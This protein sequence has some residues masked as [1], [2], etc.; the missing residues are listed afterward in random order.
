MVGWGDALYD[1][2]QRIR[3]MLVH[4]E[5]AG[6][7]GLSILGPDGR[8]GVQLLV[9]SEGDP[10]FNITDQRGLRVA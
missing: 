8:N 1:G 10:S 2:D 9:S 7:A 5:V 3:A 6:V 4:G